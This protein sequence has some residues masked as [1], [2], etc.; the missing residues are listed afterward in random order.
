MKLS[1]KRRAVELIDRLVQ[2]LK[3]GPGSGPRPGHGRKPTVEPA[4]QKPTSP[5]PPHSSPHGS[6]AESPTHGKTTFS[7]KPANPK[8]LDSESQFKNPDG[9]WTKERQ[10]L[11]DSIVAQHLASAS[12]VKNPEAHMMGGGPASGK[13]VAQGSGQM[14]IPSNHVLIDADAIKQHL[15]EYNSMVAA[16]DFNA[17]AFAHEESSYL[18]KRILKEAS[19]KSYN[20]MLDGTGDSGIKALESKIG[21]MKENGAK[22]VANYVTVQTETALERNRARAA[23]TGRLPPEE[24]VRQCHKVVSQ[25]VPEAIKRGLFD[26]FS[27]YDTNG[28]GAK[29]IASAKGKELTIHDEHLWNQFLAK[30]HE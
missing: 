11:H 10:A 6:G 17:A 16:K 9:S 1:T 5:E 23:K 29:K 22:V 24:M 15:P 14:N 25:V 12:P 26:E 28:S 21:M 8:G 19:A 2:I 30:G 27:L 3:G 20:T 4:A 18:S 7:G 13:S